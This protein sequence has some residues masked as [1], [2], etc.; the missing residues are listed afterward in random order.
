MIKNELTSWVWYTVQ[1]QDD[2]SWG[3]WA[4]HTTH[5]SEREALLE[6]EDV[7]AEGKVCRVV[8]VTTDVIA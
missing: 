6:L 3:G 1:I 2:Q 5:D 7:K 4:K 8:R